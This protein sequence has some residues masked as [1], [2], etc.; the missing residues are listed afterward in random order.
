MVQWSTVRLMLILSAVLGL[1][2]RQVDFVQAFPQAP[3]ED[4]VYMRIPQ[5]FAYDQHTGCLIQSDDPR[6]R[7]QQYCIK[8]K[9]N[10]YGCKQASRNWFLHLSQGLEAHGFVASKTDPCLFIRKDAIICLYTD[11]CCVFAKDNKIID[12]LI[13][14]LSQEFLLKDEGTIEDFLGV[15]IKKVQTKNGQQIHLTQTGLIKDVLT[16]LGI[17]GPE[18][19]HEKHDIPTWEVLTL[20]PDGEPFNAKWSYRSIIGKLNFLAQNMHPDIAYAVHQCAKYSINPKQSHGLAVKRI[21]RY[22]KTTAHLGLILRPDGSHQLHT[23]SDSDFAG[24]WTTKYAHL[25]ESQLSRAGC[26]I[27]YSGCPIYWFS[28]LET[29][30]A[31]STCKAEYI[32]LSMSCRQ[33]IP[34]RRILEELYSIFQVP[35]DTSHTKVINELGCSVVLED[36]S[37]ALALANDGDKYLPQTK[38]LSLKWHHF[39]DQ[40]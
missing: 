2:S 1:A 17:N 20:D 36:N 9:R 32:A 38:H 19:K 35:F 5:G 3:L 23:Y 29:E 8:L 7:D 24:N 13:A 25:C 28:K 18:A 6:H 26:V 21:G 22:L 12:N 15:H 31:L 10:L 40:I 27:T 34:L 33:L 16:E 11:D 30:I 37:A 39:C 14:N 4:D